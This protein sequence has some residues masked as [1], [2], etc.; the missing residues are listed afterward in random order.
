MNPSVCFLSA[1]SIHSHFVIVWHL[2]GTRGPKQQHL[3]GLLMGDSSS[4]RLHLDYLGRRW[5]SI[6]I[7]IWNTFFSLCDENQ[8][9][10]FPFH[11]NVRN[12]VTGCLV[13][14]CD[15]NTARDK[16]GVCFFWLLPF[17]YLGFKCPVCSKSVASNEM[18]V[19][20]I[21]C[22]SKPRLS[23]NGK[24][25]L[26]V[27]LLFLICYLEGKAKLAGV[28]GNRKLFIFSTYSVIPS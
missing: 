2:R 15:T 9:P 13:E 18:E 4:R 26:F 19:H 6:I 27:S 28:P 17:V 20:F 12:D 21:M 22:L 7:K 10:L 23:Y 11:L 14:M 3:S 1:S 24:K 8:S 16:A 5:M 25:H